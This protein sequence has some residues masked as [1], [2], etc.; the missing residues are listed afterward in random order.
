M[1]EIFSAHGRNAVVH[2]QEQARLMHSTTVQP[3]HLL[4]GL[5]LTESTA[6]ELIDETGVTADELRDRYAGLPNGGGLDV[7]ALADLG[8]DVDRLRERVE[9]AFGS[10]ALDAPPKRWRGGHIPFAQPCKQALQHALRE[11]QQRD[12]KTIGTAHVL[13]GLIEAD[14]TTLAALFVGDDDLDR[15]R[16]ATIDRLAKKA[17]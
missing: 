6:R 11:A 17:A 1:F 7:E 8:I 4:I 15:L 16:S 9:S 14:P 12:H 13:L 3:A 5:A 10:G 2:A